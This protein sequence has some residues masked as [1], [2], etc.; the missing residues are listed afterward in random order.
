MTGAESAREERIATLSLRDVGFR[1]AGGSLTASLDLLSSAERVGLVGDWAP[2]FRALTGEVEVARGSAGIFECRIDQALARGVVG[3]ALCD[4]PLPEAFSVREYLEHAARLSHGSKTRAV[5]DARRTLDELDL[6]ELATRPL[7]A[8][9]HFQRRA[10]GVAFASVTAP[11]VLCLE[12]PLQGLDA[13]SADYVARLCAHVAKRSRLIV[14][15]LAPTSPSPEHSLLATCDELFLLQGGTLLAYGAPAAVLAPSARYLFT[16]VGER[17]N[18]LETSLSRSGCRLTPQA[19]PTSFDA[20][21]APNRR[22]TRYLIELPVTESSDRLL[23]AALALGLTVL[24]LQPLL[25]S[26]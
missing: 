14:S 20:W 12:T 13:P 15:A 3:V 22:V 17:D 7:G 10:L 25:E 23:D 19:S 6:A 2:L 18:E 24:E 21:L 4:P 8:L 5:S 11:P 16:L 1:D 9:V 26:S